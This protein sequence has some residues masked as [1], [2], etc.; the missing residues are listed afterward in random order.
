MWDMHEVTKVR[1]PDTR[2]GDRETWTRSVEMQVVEIT[3]PEVDVSQIMLHKRFRSTFY[4]NIAISGNYTC[5]SG[6]VKV[7]YRGE[8]VYHIKFD[9]GVEGDLDFSEYL[10]GG[11]IFAALKNK[12]LFSKATVE[13]GTI[14][15]PNGADVAPETLY[16]RIVHANQSLK[17]T[18]KK[19]AR[20]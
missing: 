18:R 19:A 13:G 9:D 15:W 11:P 2:T 3:Y 17:R 10:S 6:D 16:E 4:V 12:P 8:Y 1:S 5:M 14:S 7:E 20:R